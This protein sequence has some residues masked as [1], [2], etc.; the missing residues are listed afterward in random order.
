MPADVAEL[1]QLPGIGSYTAR[2][3]AVFAY[4]QRHPVVDTNVRR[5]VARAI[6]G[7]GD[8]GAA[9]DRAATMPSVEALLPADPSCCGAGKRGVHGAR[10]ARVHCPRAALRRA[11]RSQ[12]R[13]AWRLAGAPVY[14]GPSVRP[15]RFA[16]TDR[17]VRGLLLDVLRA[18]TTPVTKTALDIVW[19]DSIQRERALDTLVVDGLVDPLPDGRFALP[20]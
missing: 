13:C 2:A 12:S 6:R 19:P 14:D 10:R 1:E 15:Q 16:G 3:V 17:Q 11:A 20:R 8:A 7:Q 5:V 18:A 9:V 4:G